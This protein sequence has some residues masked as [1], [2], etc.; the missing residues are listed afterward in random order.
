V[1]TYIR[2]GD[3]HYIAVQEEFAEVRQRIEESESSQMPLFEATRVDGTR[4]LLNA[5][6]IRTI[7]EG[8]KKDGGGKS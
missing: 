6:E 1:P 3:D 8:K 5:N 2:F 4:M 7:S